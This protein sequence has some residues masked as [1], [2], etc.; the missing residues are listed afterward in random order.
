M[1]ITEAVENWINGNRSCIKEALQAMQP[2]EA[3]NFALDII[4]S[5]GKE[6]GQHFRRWLDAIA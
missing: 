2:L 6:D 3:A 1:T 4:W 5:L